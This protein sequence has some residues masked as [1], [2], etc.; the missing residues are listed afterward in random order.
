[1]TITY[2]DI[3]KFDKNHS[4]KTTALDMVNEAN[5]L[6]TSPSKKKIKRIIKKTK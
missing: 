2:D 5:N 1:M 6:A 4:Y 3:K